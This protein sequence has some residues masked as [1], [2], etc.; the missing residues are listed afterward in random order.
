MTLG[1]L[2]LLLTLKVVTPDQALAGFSNEGM[3]TVAVLAVGFL[4]FYWWILNREFGCVAAWLSTL[5]LGTTAAWLGFSQMGVTDLP[6]AATFSAAMLLSLPWQWD[7][8][9]LITPPGPRLQQ[10][11]PK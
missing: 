4:A 6:L 3:I 8:R 2:T 11:S 5:I 7:M 9:R 1:V 10:T